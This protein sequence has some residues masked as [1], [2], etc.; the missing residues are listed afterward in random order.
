MILTYSGA[1]SSCQINLESAIH[2]WISWHLH[3]AND[4]SFQ[5]YNMHLTQTA[6]RMASFRFEGLLCLMRSLMSE[7]TSASMKASFPSVSFTSIGADG[8]AKLA[9]LLIAC[10]NSVKVSD[11][12]W[13]LSFNCA[14]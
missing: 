6:K 3:S 14:R 5:F 2:L 10:P 1:F 7:S 4:F 13:R 12:L 9:S 8:Y 11:A